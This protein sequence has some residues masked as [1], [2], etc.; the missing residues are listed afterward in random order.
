MKEGPEGGRSAAAAA[1]GQV[2]IASG[3]VK[4]ADFPVWFR[5]VFGSLHGCLHRS[6]RITR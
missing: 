4:E 3:D 6:L 1:R 2:L 5:A